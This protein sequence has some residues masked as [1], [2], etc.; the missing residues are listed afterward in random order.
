[1]GAERRRSHR[2]RQSK[3]GNEETD[4][5][6]DSHK[7]PSIVDVFAQVATVRLPNGIRA[8]ESQVTLSDPVVQLGSPIGN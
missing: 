1:M 5:T 2:S 6:H 3:Y 7:S 4:P 8:F